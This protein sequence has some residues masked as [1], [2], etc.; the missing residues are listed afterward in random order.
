MCVYHID[1]AILSWSASGS[2]LKDWSVISTLEDYFVVISWYQRANSQKEEEDKFRTSDQLA[3]TQEIEK[4]VSKFH[5]EVES[6]KENFS[7]AEYEKLLKQHE[8]EVA[9]LEKRLNHQ[10]GTQ[11]RSFLDKLAARKRKKSEKV[12]TQQLW[13]I[14]LLNLISS[15]SYYMLIL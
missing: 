14:S 2:N 8:E 11:K 12:M 7:E 10:M 15:S 1:G 4:K 13:S 5:R 6:R 9:L 3:V